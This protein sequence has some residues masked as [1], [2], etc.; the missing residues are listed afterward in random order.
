MITKKQ[1]GKSKIVGGVISLATVVGLTALTVATGGMA[2]PFAIAAG[3]KA[4]FA[5]ADIAEGLDGYSKMNAMDASRPANFLRDTVFGGNQAAYD[6]TS[7]ITDMVFDVVSGKAVEG[8]FSRM[9]EAS[10]VQK[11]ARKAMDFWDGICPKTKVANLVSQIGGTML[12]GAV[13]DYLATGKVDLKNLGLDA[14]AGLAKG[15]LGTAG[16]EKL[17]KYLD[18]DDKWVG[19]VVGTLAGAAFG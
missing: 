16:T 18:I 11:L 10:K 4:T 9:E 19:K 17:K 5:V 8:A 15:T 2:A 13:D 3:V 12:F 7:M 1:E 6:T 14:L